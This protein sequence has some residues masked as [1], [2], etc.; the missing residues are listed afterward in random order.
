[1]PS[2]SDRSVNQRVRGAA[3][4]GSTL[5]RGEIRLTGEM[6]SRQYDDNLAMMCTPGQ[7][8]YSFATI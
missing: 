7:S 2:H 5:V 4:V 3:E 8:P 1:M 6:D